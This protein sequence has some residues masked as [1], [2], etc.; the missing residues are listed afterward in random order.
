MW[1]RDE[2]RHVAGLH[3]LDE[4]GQKVEVTAVRPDADALRTLTAHVLRHGQEVSAAIESMTG[5]RFVHDPLELCGWEVAIAD[6]AKV[7]DVD[8][9]G[10]R[11]HRG[12]V[13]VSLAERDVVADEGPPGCTRWTAPG[14]TRPVSRRSEFPIAI[15]TTFDEN[16]ER[17]T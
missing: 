3:V 1:R 6:A 10:L 5:A 14:M 11:S 13:D 2:V 4:D 16:G 7:P 12:V 15:A 9:L 8:V 17:S